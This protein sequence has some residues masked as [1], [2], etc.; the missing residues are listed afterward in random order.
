MPASTL[1][2]FQTDILDVMDEDRLYQ[3]DWNET[4]EYPPL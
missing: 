4:H 1:E 3:A 2:L